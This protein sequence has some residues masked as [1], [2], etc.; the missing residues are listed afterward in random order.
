MGGRTINHLEADELTMVE[1]LGSGRK[2][3]CLTNLISL[4]DEVTGSMD[5]VETVQV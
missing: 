1:R 4:A 2:R 3:S 5:R